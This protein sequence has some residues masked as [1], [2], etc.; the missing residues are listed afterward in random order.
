MLIGY[1]RVSTKDQNADLQVNALK[2][3]GCEKVY[4]EK[5]SGGDR[6]RPILL[7]AVGY[8]RSGVDVLVVWKLDRLARSIRHLLELTEQLQAENIGFRS[9]TENIDTTTPGGKLIFHI[10]ASLAEFERELIRE[11]VMAGLQAARE[12]GKLGGRKHKLTAKDV[13]VAKTLLLDSSI[14][15]DEVASRMK[16]CPATLYRYFPGGRGAL[17]K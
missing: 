10:F 13:A 17:S 16:I 3:A 8:M 15:A 5:A 6:S 12:R 11:R 14:S 9:L 2:A 1:A 7:E 4:I